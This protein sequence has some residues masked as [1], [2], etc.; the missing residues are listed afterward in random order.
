MSNEWDC[1]ARAVA[2]DFNLSYGACCYSCG[3]W[4]NSCPL[5][6]FTY[7]SWWLCV[8][9]MC[10]SCSERGCDY[11][12]V[13]GFFWCFVFQMRGRVCAVCLFAFFFLRHALKVPMIHVFIVYI[14]NETPGGTT[15]PLTWARRHVEG[16]SAT[17]CTEAPFSLTEQPWKY[18]PS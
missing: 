6:M 1:K 16:P 17:I 3:V 8:W 7:I 9:L 11:A 14:S 18:C 4:V 5:L 12:H 10:A 15:I 2:F 13:C